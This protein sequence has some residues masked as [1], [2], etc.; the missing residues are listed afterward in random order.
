M[1]EETHEKFRNISQSSRENWLHS[2][3]AVG[4]SDS[5]FDCNIS[6]A[7]LTM[8]GAKPLN[9]KSMLM[10][11]RSGVNSFSFSSFQSKPLYSAVPPSK[12]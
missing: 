7:W 4:G 9:V 6:A 2:V 10:A 1:K 12:G 11:T 8:I 5:Y 3:V